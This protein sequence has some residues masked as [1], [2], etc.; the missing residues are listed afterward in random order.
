MAEPGHHS[1]LNQYKIPLIWIG[2]IDHRTILRSKILELK[3]L[4]V[5]YL[6]IQLMRCFHNKLIVHPDKFKGE[7]ITYRVNQIVNM[8]LIEPNFTS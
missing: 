5:K 7:N 3:H 8:I 2:T 6:P 1:K 4:R